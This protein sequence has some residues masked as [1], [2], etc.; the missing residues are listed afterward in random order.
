MRNQAV[1]YNV[2]IRFQS[3]L[4][5]YAEREGHS[6]ASIMSNSASLNVK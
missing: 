6:E 2:A 4:F 1:D 3:F 5:L